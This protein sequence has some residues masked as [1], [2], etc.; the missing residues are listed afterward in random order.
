MAKRIFDIIP[1]EEV[2]NNHQSFENN[3]N[4]SFLSKSAPRPEKIRAERQ[5]GKPKGWI[6]WFVLILAFGILATAFFIPAKAEI[7][8]YPKTDTVQLTDTFVIDPAQTEINSGT[9]TLPGITFSDIQNIAQ[10]YN[11][12]GSDQN[13]AKARGTIRVYSKFSPAEALTLKSGT[14]FLSTPK[15]LSYHSL[16]TINIP[17]ATVSGGKVTPAYVDIQIEADEAGTDYNM[18]SATFSVPKLNGT[19][20]YSTTWAQTQG[21]ITGGTSSSVKIVSKQDIDSAKEDFKTKAKDQSLA[22]L[23]AKI[24]SDY[25][26][27]DDAISQTISNIS[28]DAK[29]KD[30]LPS[31]NVTGGITS[32]V[33]TY[34]TADLNALAEQ[35]MASNTDQVKQMV[36]NTVNCTV[37]SHTINKAG[38]I[39]ITANCTAKTYWL[40]DSAFLT[41]SL[42]GKSKDYSASIL[43]NIT[44]ID[45]VQINISP[46]W[47]FNV[48]K[49]SK[50]INIRVNFE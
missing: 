39:E 43:K 12:T 31:F 20:Y 41:K 1:P 2:Q 36:P 15:A 10:K 33:I 8:I 14:H 9:K 23:K 6:K 45:R 44:E 37:I 19:A 18:A 3:D 22:A 40:P 11:A 47:K 26:V 35:M 27:F 46:F 21:A 38:N 29:E 17:A 24:I 30:V 13:S 50:N 49:D 5:P 28:V 32:Q 42:G 16:S 48:P 25:V 4:E 34:K 7:T